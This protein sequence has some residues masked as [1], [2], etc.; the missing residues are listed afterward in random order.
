[1][2][3]GRAPLVTLV[4]LDGWGIAPPGPGN[5]V[6]QAR[7]PVFDDL[8]QRYPTTQLVASGPAVGLP[9]GQ[10]GNSEVGHLTIGSG[11]ILYQDLVRV[12]RAVEDGSLLSNTALV[13]A[14]RRARERAGAVH[15]LGLVSTGGVHSHIDH[16][17][18]LLELGR[19][20]GLGEQTWVH[21]FT[22]GRDVSPHAAVVDLATLPPERIA[23][24]VGR[25]YA[26]DRDQ[27]WERTAR[28]LDAIVEGTGE[29]AD[30]PV[31]AVRAS[32]ERGVTDEFV[33]PIVLRGGSRL[34]PARDAAIVFNF[35]P[36]RVRQL[37]QRLLEAN[38]DVVT[39]TRYRDDFPC[40]VAF[41]EQKV[42]DTL[43]EV[44]SRAGLRQLHAAETE[45]YAHVTYFFD[46]GVEEPCA[47]EERI[48]IPSPRDVA[49][50]D[51]K[52]EMSA[53]EVAARVA[54]A[55]RD[56]YAF[57]VV[58]FANPDMVGHTG[59]IPAVVQA[60]ETVDGCLGEVVEATHRAGGVCLVTADHGNAEK[61]L[62]DD[63]VSPHT[64]HTTNPVPLVLTRPDVALRS[65]GELSD[66][67]P[68]VL[69][70]LELE[71]P[72]QMTGA[73]LVER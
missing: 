13:G 55:L 34:D 12:S 31:A 45:K 6:E 44:L 5:A 39:M 52:P 11:R 41:D 35:R 72:V 17:R 1:M 23:T 46:G 2:S 7:T 58:N 43:A 36:D 64:A 18:A 68:T 47:G 42:E 15:L 14:F 51:L 54:E 50:Y 53:P 25:Y 19:R 21:A 69:D 10:M 33:E 9:E 28:A 20:E 61:L 24:V 67:A 60:V 62:E 8:S 63:G 26:M 29:Q 70:L 16:L 37:T 27:R 32:Y 57:C 71:Q 65:G 59:A 30:D 49:S 38:T 40:P 4:I 73:S 66:L 22:D 48:L 3:T 56:G